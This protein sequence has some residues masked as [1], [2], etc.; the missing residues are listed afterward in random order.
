LSSRQKK[1]KKGPSTYRTPP[2]AYDIRAEVPRSRASPRCIP[3]VFGLPAKRV[4]RPPARW[5]RDPENS[6]RVT[7][8]FS[9]TRPG[10]DDR[11]STQVL[12]PAPVPQKM[13]AL[14]FAPGIFNL[15]QG[16]AT[17]PAQASRPAGLPH[18]TETGYCIGSIDRTA[19][20]GR[21]RLAAGSPARLPSCCPNPVAVPRSMPLSMKLTAARCRRHR[22]G[23]REL[24]TP[25]SNTP[26][27]AGK[28]PAAARRGTAGP[29]AP[30]ARR[31]KAAVRFPP[32]DRWRMRKMNVVDGRHQDRRGRNSACVCCR[33]CPCFSCWRA[34]SSARRP[35]QVARE[36]RGGLVGGLH[37]RQ[38]ATDS[39][40][41]VPPRN[42]RG[43][44]AAS[45]GSIPFLRAIR[46]PSGTRKVAK[47]ASP[48]RLHADVVGKRPPSQ[49]PS[50][51]S[52]ADAAVRSAEGSGAGI[53]TRP[54]PLPC[55]SWSTND[56]GR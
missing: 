2:A 17:G 29:P 19:R 52:P 36:D 15:C 54:C 37:R 45:G 21:F 18:V 8:L 10:R 33:S 16:S 12:C 7:N 22:Q 9:P 25:L 11:P 48:R 51:P 49:Q 55:I 27:A 46:A 41:H 38:P 44:G 23:W 39:R 3:T 13:T 50:L 28:N 42:S 32:A 53:S 31:L 34:R 14:D 35:D 20:G 43:L 1:R 24:S 40:P 30:A 4:Q 56:L 5:P 26:A 47:G 6:T